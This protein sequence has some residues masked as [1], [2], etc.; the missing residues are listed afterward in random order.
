MIKPKKILVTGSSGYVGGRL[1]PKLIDEGY[2]VR[3]LVRNPQR[4]KDKIWYNKVDV[5]KG[6]VLDQKSIIG[7]F[8]DI[9]AAYYLIHSM[10]SNK[11]FVKSD[12]IAA[13]NFAKIAH[14][15]N[16]E[17]I[18]YL[19]GLADESAELSE[20]LKSRHDTGKELSKFGAKVIE[21][22]ANVIVGSGSLSFE[23]KRSR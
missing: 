4:I 20:H 17:N 6:N 7:L 1:V 22:R 21:F 2:Q 5:F 12:L 19:G 11:D 10:E 13:N 16:L 14:R 3:V 18:V 15:E 23:S 8:K 9:D